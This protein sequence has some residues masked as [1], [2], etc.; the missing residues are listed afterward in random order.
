MLAQLRARFASVS[1]VA[2][3]SYWFVFGGTLIN[4]LGGFVVPLLTIYLTKVRGVGV[5]EA[6]LVAAPFGGRSIVGSL[7]CGPGRVRGRLRTTP[8]PS[9][10]GGSL[11]VLARGYLRHLVE[12]G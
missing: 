4:R 11:V 5:A 12:S 3:R 7:I 9:L 10:S 1:A 2:P 8:L 6:G